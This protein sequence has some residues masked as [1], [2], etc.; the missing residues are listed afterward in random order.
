MTKVHL[1]FF[2]PMQGE[3]GT[4]SGLIRGVATKIKKSG[5]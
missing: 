2:E 4:S 5:I 3:Y 1:D